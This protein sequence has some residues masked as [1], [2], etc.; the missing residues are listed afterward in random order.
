MSSPERQ[1]PE[2]PLGGV[3]HTYQRYDAR[4]FP[5]PTQPPP[6]LV[7]SAFASALSQPNTL[8]ATVESF[9]SSGTIMDGLTG[10]AEQRIG[11]QSGFLRLDAGVAAD[12]TEAF[13]VDTLLTAVGAINGASSVG[14]VNGGSGDVVN[15]GA[16]TMTGITVGILNNKSTLPWGGTMR[17]VAVNDG[18]LSTA[19]LNAIGKKLADDHSLTWTAIA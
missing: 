8:I 16:E 15:A 13:A 11:K 9:V 4:Q 3:I 19:E 7:S 12:T 10:A 1:R 6:D 18:A 17:Q 5:S 2:K 14:Y